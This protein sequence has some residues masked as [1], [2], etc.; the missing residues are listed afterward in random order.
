MSLTLRYPGN[1]IDVFRTSYVFCFSKHFNRF[2]WKGFRNWQDHRGFCRRFMFATRRCSRFIVSTNT[3]ATY[4]TIATTAIINK[5]I[6]SWR[7][8]FERNANDK[9][10]HD[11]TRAQNV[12]YN[13]QYDVIS[14][15]T[16]ATDLPILIYFQYT[17]QCTLIYGI[18]RTAALLMMTMR[19]AQHSVHMLNHEHEATTAQNRRFESVVTANFPEF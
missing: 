16:H 11:C 3:A 10:L 1:H 12:N 8:R 13:I 18:Y 4:P 9:Y 7:R 6:S 14:A 17:V 2:V 19:Q 5:L 15:N